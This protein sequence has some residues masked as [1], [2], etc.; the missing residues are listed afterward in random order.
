MGFNNHYWHFYNVHKWP[1]LTYNPPQDVFSFELH[2][3]P[4]FYVDPKYGFIDSVPHRDLDVNKIKSMNTWFFLQ[5]ANGIPMMFAG[6]EVADTWW[7]NN[8][9]LPEERIGENWRTRRPLPGMMIMIQEY[10]KRYSTTN[11]G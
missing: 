8:P 7:L 11:F 10:P 3:G 5:Q 9:W 4:R 1:G 2:D 6:N